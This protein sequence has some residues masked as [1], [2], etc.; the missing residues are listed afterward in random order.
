MDASSRNRR[1]AAVVDWLIDR[2]AVTLADRAGGR[3]APPW[4]PKQHVLLG[5]LDPIRVQPAPVT[6][7]E[8][9]AGGDPDADFGD[10]GVVTTAV[11]PGDDAAL[12]VA[13]Q[14]DGKILA[15]GFTTAGSDSD[16]AVVRYHAFGTVDDSFNAAGTATTSF[17][18]GVDGARAHAVAVQPDGKIVAAGA[19]RSSTDGFA[20][21]RYRPSGFADD[22]FDRDGRVFTPLLPGRDHVV[23]ALAVQPDGKIV[24][25]G[26]SF[27]AP[28]T[29]ADFALAR[30]RADGSLDASFGT[31]GTVVTDVG[32]GAGSIAAGE[33]PHAHAVALQPD[34]GIVA[35]GSALVDGNLDFAVV[36][37]TPSGTPDP[38]F[39]GGDGIVTTA[40]SPGDDEIRSL[41]VGDDG[42]ITVAGWSTGG[43]PGDFALAR[44][45]SDGTLD[46]TFGPGGTG[47][48]VTALSPGDD[49][50]SGMVADA[51]PGLVVAGE[52][53]VGTS[54][55]MVVAR[56]GDDGSLDPDFG[57]G[58]RV[59]APVGAGD[60]LA[61]SIAT[62]PDGALV[63]AGSAEAA[64]PATG[65]DFAVAGFLGLPVLSV[66]EVAVTEGN[67]GQVAAEFNL[68][69][70]SPAGPR[71]AQVRFSTADDT[72]TAGDDYVATDGVAS[73]AAGETATTVSVPVRG[74]R[75]DE[76]A[77]RFVL[78]LSA[79]R[80][81]ILGGPE[82]LGVIT[83]DEELVI[84][85]VAGGPLLID[86]VVVFPGADP[87]DD[88][89]L[90]RLCAD[91]RRSPCADFSGAPPGTGPNPRV[92]QG[93]SF[94]AGR[95]EPDS[96]T[97]VRSLPGGTGL[98]VGSGLEIEL[99]TPAPAVELTLAHRIS[100][101]RVMAVTT[102]GV[103]LSVATTSGPPGAPNA[104]RVPPAPASGTAQQP[105]AVAAADRFVYVA[106]PVNHLVRFIDPLAS[107]GNGCPC[108]T[109]FAGNGARG[110]AA[111]GADPLATELGGPYAIAP[112]RTAAG[113]VADMYI[114][115]TF[116]HRVLRV[117]PPAPGA[118]PGTAP[119]VT[120]V[121]GT[122]AFGFG[123][124]GGAAPD[125]QLNSP[126]GVAHD[127]ARNV[128][129]VAD[130]LNHRVRAVRADGTI[131]TVAGD[132]T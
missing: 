60:A 110:G 41:V 2:L 46:P 126:Y 18:E 93:V 96:T 105:F 119:K 79:P 8:D 55:A 50:A 30:Y 111:P 127:E 128:T 34:G 87:D 52:T 86:R 116:G 95:P 108:E 10:D 6:T 112:R 9:A 83:D 38:S 48:V 45:A 71:G 68:S 13:V 26:G 73:I 90:V 17:F 99:A 35:A 114:A 19:A 92:E 28:R 64:P 11:G 22:T 14:P 81:A 40:V 98:D 102:A 49:R 124:D 53:T 32:S 51:G 63:V 20:L 106:D 67:R 76:P 61:T 77:E 129:Y 1:E 23:H 72:A 4:E 62:R 120:V 100:P 122:G 109:V 78:R 39:G 131:T 66:D 91:P 37:Y 15:A 132:G 42:R 113:V 82:A 29:D 94:L 80:G 130:T 57:T 107:A 27:R 74:D 123:G 58:G 88:D 47:T 25:A 16:F 7:G 84:D 104:V 89:V 69:L 121:A 125:A 70:S 33:E 59:I 12:S 115:D 97:A 24:A 75:R 101:P 85:T 117:A 31:A 54:R 103:A 5:V 36:R 43:G 44:Y 3:H 118:P 56:Y 65:S 21:A